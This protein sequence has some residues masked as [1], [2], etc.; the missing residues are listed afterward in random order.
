MSTSVSLKTTAA[1][2]GGSTLHD[3]TQP[4]KRSRAPPAS[5]PTKVAKMEA[6]GRVTPAKPRGPKKAKGVKGAK[7]AKKAGAKAGAKL[8]SLHFAVQ[9]GG[10]GGMG[11]PAALVVV[12]DLPKFA[13]LHPAHVN[14]AGGGDPSYPD[15]DLRNLELYWRFLAHRMYV[16]KGMYSGKGDE[17]VYSMHGVETPPSPVDHLLSLTTF[18]EIV[19]MGP[20]KWVHWVIVEMGPLPTN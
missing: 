6:A 9:E 4:R 16:R 5:T 3:D 19:E 15:G 20:L 17:Y 10:G 13:A 8:K 1:D 12:N 14:V 2:D 18:G 11:A 7:R